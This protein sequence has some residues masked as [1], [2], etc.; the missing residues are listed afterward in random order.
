[1]AY[2]FRGDL[3]R[4]GLYVYTYADAAGTKKERGNLAYSRGDESSSFKL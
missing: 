2:E 3:A 4:R 1:M